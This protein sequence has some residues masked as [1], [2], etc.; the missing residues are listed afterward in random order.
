MINNSNRI[1]FYFGYDVPTDSQKLA[2]PANS[3][4]AV[5][6]CIGNVLKKRISLK[7]NQSFHIPQL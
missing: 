5:S 3:T 4:S 7:I 6:C 2:T 1:S